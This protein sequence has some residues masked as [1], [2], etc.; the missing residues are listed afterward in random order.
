MSTELERAQPQTLTIPGTG[1]VVNPENPVEVA[2]ALDSVCDLLNLLGSTRR[3]LTQVLVEEAQRQGTK[4]LHLEGATVKIS[5]GQ[6]LKWDV[7]KL[8][9]LRSAGLPEVRLTDFLKPVLT[10]KP[11]GRIAKQLEGSGN[12]DYSRIIS[13]A[14]SYE[15]APWSASVEIRRQRDE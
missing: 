4:T 3:A 2:R 13:E 12:P 8:L 15:E 1:E 9:E 10:Y 7:G 14:R 6:R 11:D 5:G